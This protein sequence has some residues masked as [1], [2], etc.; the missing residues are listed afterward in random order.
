MLKVIFIYVLFTA[1][2]H[3]SSDYI[4]S[5]AHAKELYTSNMHTSAPDNVD[6]NRH[7]ITVG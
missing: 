3:I 4:I 1:P 7:P 6:I 2:S 5:P